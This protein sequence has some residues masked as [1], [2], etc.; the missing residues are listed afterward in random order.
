MAGRARACYPAGGAGG[1][2][3]RRAGPVLTPLKHVSA[4]SCATHACFMAY[5]QMVP[6][7]SK[8]A[9]PEEP[10]ALAAREGYPCNDLPENKMLNT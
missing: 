9:S 8:S 5:Q 2:G 10:F 7:I 1:W 4:P 3:G 6:V